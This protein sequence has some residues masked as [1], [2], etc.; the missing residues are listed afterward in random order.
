MVLTFECWGRDADAQLAWQMMQEEFGTF[1]RE[2]RCF[3]MLP[4]ML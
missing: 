1:E 3:S 4:A 2:S